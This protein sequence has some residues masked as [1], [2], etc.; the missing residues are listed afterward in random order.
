MNL[1]QI[2]RLPLLVV[3]LSSHPHYAYSGE[4]NHQANV[5]H[6]KVQ[7]S[8]HDTLANNR[9]V[10]PIK[11]GTAGTDRTRLIWEKMI[12]EQEDCN[13]CATRQPFPGDVD[14]TASNTE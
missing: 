11:T 2:I 14:Q 13:N 1:R 8:A 9:L 12:S 5:K 4:Q 6:I 7:R 3:A 10:D